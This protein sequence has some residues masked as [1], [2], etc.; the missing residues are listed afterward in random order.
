MSTLYNNLC[1]RLASQSALLK[2]G[3]FRWRTHTAVL[4][5]CSPLGNHESRSC[6]SYSQDNRTPSAGPAQLVVQIRIINICNR[7]VTRHPPKLL[8]QVHISYDEVLAAGCREP[9]SNNYTTA[10]TVRRSCS[11]DALPGT[12]CRSLSPSPSVN[13]LLTVVA[14]LSPYVTPGSQA[15]INKPTKEDL[16]CAETKTKTKFKHWGR[17]LHLML[18]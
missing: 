5:H 12:G 9:A 7:Q 8:K 4:P 3:V 18:L 13:L 15:Y 1:S 6:S 10:V 14:R 16:E 2:E 11:F 17:T